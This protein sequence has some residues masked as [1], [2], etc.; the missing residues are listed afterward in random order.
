MHSRKKLSNLK[1]KIISFFAEIVNMCQYIKS[2]MIL[3]SAQLFL[4]N[5]R[6]KAVIKKRKQNES[7]YKKGKVRM[8]K[9]QIILDGKIYI[10]RL[11]HMYHYVKNVNVVA[12]SNIKMLSIWPRSLFYGKKSALILFIYLPM[13]VTDFWWLQ[14]VIYVFWLK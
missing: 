13:K 4:N 12:Y 5:Y 2:L 10:Y 1:F 11:K 14:V 8:N 6:M 9:L 7:S 3:Q